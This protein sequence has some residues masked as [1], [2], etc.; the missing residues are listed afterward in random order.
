MSL[1]EKRGAMSCRKASAL[2]TGSTRSF[3]PFV[4]DPAGEAGRNRP[5][6]YLPDSSGDQVG[7]EAKEGVGTGCSTLPVMSTM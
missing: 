2:R 6:A 1:L 3:E 4:A 5:G 7:S